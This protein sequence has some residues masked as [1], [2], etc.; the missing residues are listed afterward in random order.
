MIR[1][2][3]AK[4]G[5]DFREVFKL[6]KGWAESKLEGTGFTVDDESIKHVLN[7]LHA[8]S[9]GIVVVA[10]SEDGI[11]GTLVGSIS[12]TLWDVEQKR[13]VCLGIRVVPGNTGVADRL[14]SAFESWADQM[15]ARAVVFSAIDRMD[16]F[17]TY[18]DR[19]GYR[20]IESY[21]GKEI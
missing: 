8:L 21:F 9:D 17:E 6:A 3:K 20:K 12:P 11:V 19:R 15:G 4:L 7:T 16:A 10:E 2:R 14:I 5:Q 18:I 13:A 1:V